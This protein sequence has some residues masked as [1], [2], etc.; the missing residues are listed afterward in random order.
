MGASLPAA[1]HTA[2][3]FDLDDD[4]A[5]RAWRSW[6]LQHAA[7][8]PAALLVELRDPHAPSAAERGALLQRIAHCNLALYACPARGGNWQR[9]VRRLTALRL[10]TACT[11]NCCPPAVSTW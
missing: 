10:P 8:D 2:S 7:T 6:K 9:Y 4:R 1:A 11:R 5:Y 3:P